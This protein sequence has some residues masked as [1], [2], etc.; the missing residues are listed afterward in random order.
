MKWLLREGGL[1][2]VQ[3]FTL[4][5]ILDLQFESIWRFVR[6]ALNSLPPDG[7]V[8][9][10]GAG[11]APFRHKFDAS[12]K[13]VTVDPNAPA[14]YRTLADLPAG[15][16]AD[17]AIAFEVL[18]HLPQPERVLTELHQYVR[19][20]A[21]L[22]ITV[23]FNARVHGAPDDFRRWTPSGIRQ[24]LE[25]SGWTVER[26]EAR[27]NDLATLAAKFV[28]L[29]ARRL[30]RLWTAIPAASGLLLVGLPLLLVGHLC[31]WLDLGEK[32]DALGFFV[33]AR[34]S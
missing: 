17:L 23:P 25:G 9:D 29:C 2:E 12:W 21:R 4:R 31:L 15:F 14:D 20:D 10:F 3:A 11:R 7:V 16:R 1:W 18:E 34:A 22:W 8:L 24:L 19:P 30:N 28:F 6:E 27:G 26:L 13:Y 33:I 32:D 5:R